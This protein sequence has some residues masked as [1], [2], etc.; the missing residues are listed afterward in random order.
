MAL[1]D[2][3]GCG[4]CGAREGAIHED[5][6]DMERCAFCGGQR[7]SCGCYLDHFYP[8]HRVRPDHFPEN[9]KTMTREELAAAAG[10]PLS[11]YVNGLPDDQQA[12][13]D[14]I[15]AEKG[16]VPFISYPNIC[17]RCGELW[18][19]MFHVTD[20][21]WEEYVQVSERDEMI[22][23]SCYD[24]I[25]GYVDRAEKDEETLP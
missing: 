20:E 11:V 3:A 15:E 6:C 17:R 4:D 18:P 19:G 8:E 9:F 12:E 7:I 1:S 21:E 16:R 25:K 24:Q 2:Q 23:R 22:C 13:W 10:L 5:G 14:R